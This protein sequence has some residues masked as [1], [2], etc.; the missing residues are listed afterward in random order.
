MLVAEVVAHLH[1]V[2]MELVVLE[3][4]EMADKVA[5]LELLTRAVVAVAVKEAGELDTLVALAVLA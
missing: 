5:L 4:V 2:Q 1:Q 3:A